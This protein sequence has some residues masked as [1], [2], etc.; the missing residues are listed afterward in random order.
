MASAESN[1][2]PDHQPELHLL[3]PEAFKP[4]WTSLFRGF[5][6]FVFPPKFS[7][8]KLES[9]PIPVKDIWGFNH[10]RKTGMMGSTVAHIFTLGIIIGVTFIPMSRR[11]PPPAKLQNRI[12]VID[13]VNYPL[14]PALTQAGGGGG[15]GDRDVLQA[16]A[17]RLPKF[18]MRQITPPEAV[19][20]NPNPQ[21]AIAPPDI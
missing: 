15:G 18:S 2:T 19:I 6:E 5:H 20:R 4:L 9:R 11:V 21:L 8:L 17:G 12:E 7:P 10:Y 3:L 14:N 13:F 1:P 16:S